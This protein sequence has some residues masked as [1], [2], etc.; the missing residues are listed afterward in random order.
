MVISKVQYQNN[1]IEQ[2]KLLCLIKQIIY[3]FMIRIQI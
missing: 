3:I 1:V 2:P